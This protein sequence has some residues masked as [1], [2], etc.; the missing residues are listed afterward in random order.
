MTSFGLP[1]TLECEL[2]NELFMG[3]CIEL[4]VFLSL[5]P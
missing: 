3:N 5:K 4:T 2:S 1:F